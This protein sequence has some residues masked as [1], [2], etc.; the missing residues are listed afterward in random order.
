LLHIAICSAAVWE[1]DLQGLKK[2][3]PVR[4]T[5]SKPAEVLSATVLYHIYKH[6]KT[7]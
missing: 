1:K 7:D 3:R 4:G 6:D 2:D 5:D